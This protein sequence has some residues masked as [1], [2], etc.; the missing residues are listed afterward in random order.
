M[1]FVFYLK[2]NRVVI[3]ATRDILFAGY[4]VTRFLYV[5]RGKNRGLDYE[6]RYRSPLPLISIL[7]PIIV[8]II[9]HHFKITT[10]LAMDLS[11]D[12]S[13][14]PLMI[15]IEHCFIDQRVYKSGLVNCLSSWNMCIWLKNVCNIHDSIARNKSIRDKK[16]HENVV[17]VLNVLIRIYQ[18]ILS[19][20]S[21][22][23]SWFNVPWAVTRI[24]LSL[25]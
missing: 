13:D 15:F 18:R 2:K 9:F 20:R 21:R 7:Q 22:L 14:P 11:I 1:C 16:I 6:S 4:I 8:I 17:R 25:V 23:K 5:D 3:R 19:K 10:G 12:L 24:S